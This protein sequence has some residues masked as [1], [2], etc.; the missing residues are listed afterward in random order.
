M[1]HTLTHIVIVAIVGFAVSASS[2]PLLIRWARRPST[3]T[4][5]KREIHHLQADKIPRFGGAA[6]FF[7]F[8]ACS[9][10]STLCCPRNSLV[11][12]AHVAVV[13]GCLAMFALGFADDLHPL[14]ARFKLLVQ[15][16][17]ATAVWSLGVGIDRLNLPL[18]GVVELAGLSWLITVLWLV[19]LTNLINLIDGVDGLA[20][21]ICLILMVLLA[22]ISGGDG[23]LSLM[24]V[25]MAGALV[26][27]L[28]YNFPPAKIY[29][30]DGGAYFLGFYIAVTSMVGSD[31][32]TVV[33]ALSAPLF[34]LALP[35]LDTL[36][37]IL[38]RALKGLPIFRA[39]QGHLHHRLLRSGV[40]S[41]RLLLGAYGL[42]V[43]FLLLGLGSF[44]AQ[45]RYIPVLVGLGV[46]TLLILGTQFGFSRRWFAVN[47]VLDN[48]LGMRGEVAYVMAMVK[49][50]EQEAHR[51]QT[52]EEFWT[53]FRDA[54]QRIGL[55]RLRLKLG[56]QERGWSSENPPEEHRS[57]RFDFSAGGAGMLEM[58]APVCRAH[59]HGGSA[60]MVCEVYGFNRRRRTCVGHLVTFEV[61]TELMAECWHKAAHQ[62]QSEPEKPLSFDTEVL[63]RQNQAGGKVSGGLLA[64]LRNLF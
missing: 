20:G 43:F 34:V 45:G 14:G 7:A 47:R 39:D 53:H 32:G 22:L 62:L 15:V 13:G 42:S 50:L 55:S 64:R 25:G 16:L 10:A 9:L 48:S 8:A 17:V 46:L 23:N 29:L 54:A 28:V 3:A 12:S 4:T 63:V 49:V 44:M 31:K 1:G 38:R 35:I 59:D 11:L 41:R 19:G 36:L 6:L 18:V 58:E 5:G 60:D 61:L 2:I 33:A 51:V 40:S 56:E 21:G 27:F 52:V 57:V 24:A 30:G 37:S 26:G